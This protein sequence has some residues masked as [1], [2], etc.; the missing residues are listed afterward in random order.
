MIVSLSAII[1][2]ILHNTYT[3]TYAGNGRARSGLIVLPCGAGKSLTGVA[4]CS[5]VKKSTMIM[6]I[7]NASVTQWKEQLLLWT[8]VKEKD[9]RLFTR[10]YKDILP[11]LKPDNPTVGGC[12]VVTT[13][14]MMCHSGKRSESGEVM[15]KD[16][17]AREWGLIILDEVHVAPA[18]MFRKVLTIVKAHCK[19]GMYFSCSTY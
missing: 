19:L 15:I 1:I 7:N 8:T 11:A 18:K 14:S 3:Y 17:A 2:Y 13:Y 16:I 9:I 6:C 10:E 12:I 5:K 4:A